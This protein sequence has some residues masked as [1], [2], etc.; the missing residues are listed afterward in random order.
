[1]LNDLVDVKDSVYE[2]ESLEKYV[3]S[4]YVSRLKRNDFHNVLA[5]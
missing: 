1:M 4:R 2:D 5:P 3:V